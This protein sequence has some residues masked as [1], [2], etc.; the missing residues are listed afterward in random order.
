MS[1]VAR[2][3]AD[4]PVITDKMPHNF[5]WIG[6]ILSA[7]PNA[8]IVHMQRDP[9]AVCWSIFKSSFLAEEHAYAQNLSD[10]VAYS[11]LY[12]DWMTFWEQ[13]YPGRIRHQS[14]EELTRNQEQQSRELVAWVDLPWEEQ[15]LQFHRSR[16]AVKT[17]STAQVR[18]PM[19]QGSSEKW[20][21]YEEFLTPLTD[22]F[23]TGNQPE[24]PF[25][26]KR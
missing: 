24:S 13:R 18:Q 5:R 26:P 23:G 6:Y 4:E 11:D 21:R 14:Y 16:R 22:R 3:G 9:R 25:S 8:K 7:F 2:L 19:Y 15:C 17:V 10:L 1:G 20:R 12:L